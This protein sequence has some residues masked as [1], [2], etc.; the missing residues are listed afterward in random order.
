MI[1]IEFFFFSFFFFEKFLLYW[2]RGRNFLEVIEIE[3]YIVAK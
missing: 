3:I 1:V 2:I